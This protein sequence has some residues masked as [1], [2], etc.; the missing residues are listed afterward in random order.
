VPLVADKL[1]AVLVQV[2]VLLDRGL[3]SVVRVTVKVFV[4]PEETLK[5]EGETER[6]VGVNPT[7]G[8][9]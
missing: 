6:V 5:I 8:P 3:P 7:L 4:P 2:I 1:P 9:E